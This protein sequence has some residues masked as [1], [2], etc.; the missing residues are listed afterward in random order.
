MRERPDGG[1][2]LTLRLGASETG[3]ALLL[4]ALRLA[5]VIGAGGLGHLAYLEG[6]SAT[7]GR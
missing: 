7:T 3:A 6:F 1:W 5:G 2:D 4:A